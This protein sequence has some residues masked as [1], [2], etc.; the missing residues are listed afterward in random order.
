MDKGPED[1]VSRPVTIYEVAA[2]AGVSP[3]TVSRTFSRPGRVSVRTADHVR[4]V[5]V[6]MGYR[7][8]GVFRPLAPGRT[9]IIGLAVADVTNPFYF[10]I[11]RGAEVAAN[12]AGYTLLLAD[13]QESDAHERENLTRLL[14]LVDGLLIG[15]TRTSDTVL[16][17]LAKSQPMVILNRQV[18]GLTCVLPDTKAGIRRAVEHLLALGH[19]HIHYVAG[20]DASWISGMRW[21]A[22]REAAR[23]LDFVTHRLGPN[24]PTVEAGHAVAAQLIDRGATAVVCYNDMM[25]MGLMAG[26]A[27]GG[28]RV[29][30]QVSVIGFDN[31]FASDLVT[32]ALTT[33]ASPLTTLGETAVRHIVAMIRGARSHTDSPIIV[34]VRLIVRASTGPAPGRGRR[35]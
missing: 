4:A 1:A 5:A 12:R 18:G 27:E 30:D 6:G 15:S 19:H 34:P 9:N 2:A 10:G 32:P 23:D 22:M 35:G 11:L 7:S 17:G 16:R 14:P 13:A 31:V 8:E 21:L 20:P 26:L 29:P 25:A 28:V 33:V 24:Q 3:S